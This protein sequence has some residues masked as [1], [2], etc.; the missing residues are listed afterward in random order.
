MADLSVKP[1][2]THS[3][4]VEGGEGRK[5]GMLGS[6]KLS[7]LSTAVS[8]DPGIWKWVLGAACFIWDSGQLF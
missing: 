3:S 2:E 7:L 4:G 5:E 1:F 6:Q 8:P